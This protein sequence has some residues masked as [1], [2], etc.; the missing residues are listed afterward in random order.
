MTFA[1]QSIIQDSPPRPLPV[2]PGG[3]PEELKR[4]PQWVNWKYAWDG[5]KW[6]KHP[7]NPRIGRKASSTD[8]LTWSRFEEVL[9]AYE[10]GEYDGAGFVFCS[11]DPYVG[12]DLDGCVDPETGEVAVW[13]VQV[14]KGLDSYTELSPSG[15]GVHIIVT[16]RISCSGRRGP[17]EMYSQD[18][19]FTMTGHVLGERH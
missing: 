17:V 14:I 1:P 6:T 2:E 7:Y 8:L 9:E 16:G 15:T 4:R 19:F 3:I 12:V 18:R 13:A 10:A 11:G 5:K